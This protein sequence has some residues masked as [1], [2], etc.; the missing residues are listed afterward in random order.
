MRVVTANQI[1][2]ISEYCSLLF[3]FSFFFFCLQSDCESDE[4]LFIF[5]RDLP[6]LIPDLSEELM[7]F[8]LEDSQEEVGTV[9]C[10]LYC[11]P[12]L[13]AVPS[14]GS[15]WCLTYLSELEKLSPQYFLPL[16]NRIFFS[17]CSGLFKFS[18]VLRFETFFVPPSLSLYW[19]SFLCTN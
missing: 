8:S 4:E 10:G 7:M 14:V 16:E 17:F 12:S 5:Q 18:L 1:S 19:F 3:D 9:V 6:N 2:N 15:C 13:L 11:H